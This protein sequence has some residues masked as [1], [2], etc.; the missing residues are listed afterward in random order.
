MELL[1]KISRLA[2][3]ALLLG[4]LLGINNLRNQPL[5]LAFLVV[6]IAI[7]AL[8]LRHKAPDGLIHWYRAEQ[9]PRWI[10]WLSGASFLINLVLPILDHRYRGEVFWSSPWPQASWWLGGIGL[11]LLLAGSVW[12]LKT[13]AVIEPPKPAANV[14]ESKRRRKDKAVE[15]EAELPVAPLFHLE[16][17]FYHATALSYL[18]I[19]AC[20]TSLWGLLAISVVILP[21]LFYGKGMQPSAATN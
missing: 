8:E 7:R 5:L 12:R 1:K 15:K 19:A 10:V 3:F 16:R 20:F 21:P 17:G 6:M 14:A 11:V 13:I 18:G 2:F 9:H 4:L